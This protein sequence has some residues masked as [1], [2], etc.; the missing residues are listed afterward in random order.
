MSLSSRLAIAR[1]RAALTQRQ[2]AR[3]ADCSERAVRQYE[4]GERRPQTGTIE[5]LAEVLGVEVGW[6]RAGE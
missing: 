5:R 6:L 3:L 4:A 1:N 2:L